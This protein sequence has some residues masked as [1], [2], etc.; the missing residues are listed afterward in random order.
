MSTK[1]QQIQTLLKPSLKI[2]KPVNKQ[3]IIASA[4]E[5]ELTKSP[6]IRGSSLINAF[7][8]DNA[9][10]DIDNIL[11]PK[12]NHKSHAH[13]PHS[14]WMENDDRLQDITT[15]FNKIPNPDDYMKN[16]IPQF[17]LKYV[18]SPLNNELISNAKENRITFSTEEQQIY[19]KE[20]PSKS[21][22]VFTSQ[23]EKEPIRRP[24]DPT[25]P[26]SIEDC[27]ELVSSCYEKV[28][29]KKMIKLR[30]Q[31]KKLEMK[32]GGSRVR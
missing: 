18:T 19:K 14:L 11:F 10:K 20:F 8:D 4:K 2:I 15:I 3:P 1:Y 12:E 16:L 28:L 13:S 25:G 21:N 31:M 22:L 5:Q 30:N 23:F 29:D 27:D 9:K 7:Y 26:N 17:G 32:Y 6:K 24:F